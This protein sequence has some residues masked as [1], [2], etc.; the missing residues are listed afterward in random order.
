MQI[1]SYK[2]ASL[3][4]I[5]CCIFVL[6]YH[7]VFCLLPVELARLR[8]LASAM[9]F[10]HHTAIERWT[11]NKECR[12]VDKEQAESIVSFS[13]N[14]FLAAASSSLNDVA[15]SPKLN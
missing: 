9:L 1:R 8:T 11:V 15:V 2:T 10:P 4:C 3:Y 7:I 14:V 12:Y 6:L 13:F 5:L